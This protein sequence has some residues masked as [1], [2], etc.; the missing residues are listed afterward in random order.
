MG[1]RTLRLFVDGKDMDF[2][3]VEDKKPAQEIV[4]SK[5]DLQRGRAVDVE[6][7]Q[8]RNISKLTIFVVDNQGDTDT[9]TISRIELLGDK[10]TG[11]DL[12]NLKKVG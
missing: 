8:F 5:D 6:G 9:T 7:S 12:K 11:V 3:D 1:P 10:L 2:E 4:L